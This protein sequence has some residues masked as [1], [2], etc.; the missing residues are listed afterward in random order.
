[1][2][3]CIGSFVRCKRKIGSRH[4]TTFATTKKPRSMR[5]HG[6]RGWFGTINQLLARRRRARPRGYLAYNVSFLPLQR[7]PWKLSTLLWKISRVWPAI[8]V[9]IFGFSRNEPLPFDS[10]LY[11]QWFV[12]FRILERKREREEKSLFHPFVRA[13]TP[14]ARIN[15]YRKLFLIVDSFL[16][17]KE[18][19]FANYTVS[20]SKVRN[21]T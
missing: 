16:S 12:S 14:A 3:S 5:L 10:Q 6:L 18:R 2:T 20:R 21:E 17:L 15:P 4:E 9:Q 8:S 19:I 1:M 13:S 11:R 7:I